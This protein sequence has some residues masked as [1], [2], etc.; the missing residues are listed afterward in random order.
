MK[1]LK[2]MPSF[3]LD[4]MQASKFGTVVMGGKTADVDN[5]GE[6]CQPAEIK[7]WNLLHS[8]AEGGDV[9]IIE[10]ML[11]LG[12]D[13]NSKD[14]LG[15]TPLMVAAAKGKKQAVDFLLTKG[16]DPSL[17]TL[18][19][20]NL[21]H[22]AVEGGDVSIVETVLSLGIPVDSTDKDGLTPSMIA[23]S[24]LSNNKL[25]TLEFLLRNGADP[26]LKNESG[27]N[28]LFISAQYGCTDVILF[29]RI[30]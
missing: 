28:V 1:G 2:Q 12:F 21:L 6:E 18:I 19:G 5:S 4:S 29:W 9:S 14:S 27:R 24:V 8:A 11:S 20:R 15:T 13:V 25:E 10:M 30:F 17:R 22:A 7:E 23:V 16:A 3:F 26:L